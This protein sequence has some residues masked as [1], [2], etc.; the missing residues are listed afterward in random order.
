MCGFVRLSQGGS[1]RGLSIQVSF[2]G[3]EGLTL[4]ATLALSPRDAL[5]HDFVLVLLLQSHLK[6]VM[7][8]LQ[9]YRNGR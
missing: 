7:T 4:S 1:T 8:L 5:S 2:T 9:S 3:Q 6:A